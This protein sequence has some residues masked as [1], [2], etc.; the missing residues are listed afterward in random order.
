MIY[1]N[2][3]IFAKILRNEIPCDK[4]Y[5][6]DEVLCFK[7]INPVAKI[8]VLLIPKGEFMSLE[9]FVSKAE[10]KTISSFFKKINKIVK[11]LNLE[12]SGYRIISNHGKD[13]NQEVPHFHVHILGGE[14]LGGIKNK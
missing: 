8:H 5:E 7:D 1:D 11:V 3:N 12:N 6:D 9:D 2:Q 4:I 14:N 10:S 13:A